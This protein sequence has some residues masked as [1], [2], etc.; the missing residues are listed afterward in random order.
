MKKEDKKSKAGEGK[1]TLTRTTVKDLTVRS[2]IQAG[3]KCRFDSCIRSVC[4]GSCVL[5]PAQP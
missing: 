1:L 5:T 2:N 3:R 4:I